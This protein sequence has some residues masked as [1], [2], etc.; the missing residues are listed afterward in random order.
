MTGVPMPGSLA[1]RVSAFTGV[2]FPTSPI[3][4][5]RTLSHQKTLLIISHR[6]ATLQG[7]DI[8]YEVADGRIAARQATALRSS[9]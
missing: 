8:V 5:I 4:A 9:A 6:P 2:P 1:E 7:C 3:E